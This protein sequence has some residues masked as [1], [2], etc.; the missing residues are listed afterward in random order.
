MAI[1]GPIQGVTPGLPGGILA[2]LQVTAAQV[3]SA[4]SGILCNVV[5]Q[6]AGSIT[7]NDCATT[8]SASIANQIW[9]GSMTVGQVLPL[10][11]PCSTGI[12]VSSVVT[13]TFS[14]SFT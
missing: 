7:L 14:I 3:L 2:A 8:G 6:V 12:V 13:G 5:C 11:W 4:S 10:Y 9:T 1:V